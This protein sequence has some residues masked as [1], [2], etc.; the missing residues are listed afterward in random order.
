M[1]EYAGHKNLEIASDAENFNNWMFEEVSSKLKGEILEVGSGIGTFSEKIIR[2]FPKS[3]ITL[4]DISQEYI[5]Q[6]RN[7]F[8]EKNIT[9]QKLDLNVVEHYEKIGFEKF[10]SIIALNVLEHVKNDEFALEQLYKMLRKGGNLILLIPCHKFLYNVIDSSI[11]HYRRYTKKDL[12]KKISKTKFKLEKIFYFNMIGI[13]GWYVNGNICKKTNVNDTAF[14][15]F[16]KFIPCIKKTE[17]V[18]G[19]KIGISIICYLKK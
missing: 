6:L 8:K 17:K 2:N 4:T 13:L 14:K 5:H 9:I 3:E 7:R 18:L 15:I 19:K 10:D 12:E 16:D 1:N 11:G